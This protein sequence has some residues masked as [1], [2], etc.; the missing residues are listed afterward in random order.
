[1]GTAM[2]LLFLNFKTMTRETLDKLR[3]MGMNLGPQYDILADTLEKSRAKIAQRRLQQL[4]KIVPVEEVE[5]DLNETE[6]DFVKYLF[7]IRNANYYSKKDKNNKDRIVEYTRFS[8]PNE[9]VKRER[10]FIAGKIFPVMNIF[11]SG[12]DADASDAKITLKQTSFGELRTRFGEDDHTLYN[13]NYISIDEDKIKI[14]LPKSFPGIDYEK[15]MLDFLRNGTLTEKTIGG[16]FPDY[17]TYKLALRSKAK[18]QK[19]WKGEDGSWLTAD[20]ANNKERWINGYSYIIK[21]KVQGR[22]APFKQIYDFYNAVDTWVFRLG[23]R[24]KWCKGAKTLVEA[25][26][27]LDAGTITIANDVEVILN[28]LNLGI[29]DFAITKFH[30]L[31]YGKYATTPLKEDEAYKW[32]VAFITYE[33]GT[34]APPI[35]KKTAL[36]TIKK[37]QDMAD[38]KVFD[39]ADIINWHGTGSRVISLWPPNDILPA[40]NDFM[41]KASVTDDKFRI[42]LPLLMLY[43][44]KHTPKWSGFKG[45]LN[46]DGTVKDEIKNI[47]Q[48]YVL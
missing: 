37:F 20:R 38:K 43:L 21:N 41:P 39:K 16:E 2:K 6:I 5:E 1:M 34:I 12:S 23:H 28:E 35:Y 33:Q 40:F 24:V 4:E 46:S 25:L 22:L 3:T 19:S 44:D 11:Y 30:E 31:I 42:D 15:T 13:V 26:S 36:Q 18:P 48:D 32:D 10:I 17:E 8:G 45:K 7:K 29:C 47:I 9:N 27:V 14:Y